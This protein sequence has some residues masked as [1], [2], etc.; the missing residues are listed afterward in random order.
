M[1]RTQFTVKIF[2]IS[3]TLGHLFANFLR[4]INVDENEACSV[5]WYPLLDRSKLLGGQ[6]GVLG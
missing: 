6:H 2:D 4:I 1:E 5:D 3:V